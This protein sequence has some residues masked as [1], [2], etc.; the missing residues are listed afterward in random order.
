MCRTSLVILEQIIPQLHNQGYVLT[1]LTGQ[2]KR[3]KLI[4]LFGT[5]DSEDAKNS[6]RNRT[7]AIEDARGCCGRITNC[8]TFRVNNR[9]LEQGDELKDLSTTTNV[10]EVTTPLRRKNIQSIQ[11]IGADEEYIPK[12]WYYDL[13]LFLNERETKVGRSYDIN[14]ILNENYENKD[15][16]I[17]M[18]TDQESQLSARSVPPPQSD[19]NNCKK[20]E[21]DGVC[22]VLSKISKKLDSSSIKTKPSFSAF[23]EHVA[24]NL[25]AMSSDSAKYCQKIINDAIFFAEFDNLNHTSRIVKDHIHLDRSRSRSQTLSPYYRPHRPPS[26]QTQSPYQ[27]PNEQLYRSPFT[28]IQLYYQSPNE[29]SDKLYCTPSVQ[30]QP[31]YQSPNVQSDKL[32]CTPSTQTQPP[33][34]SP[35]EQSDKLYRTPSTQTQPPYQSPNEQ[36]DRPY[37]TPS[38]QTQPPYQS[39]NEQSD[40]LYRTPS[41]Q[42]QPPYQS[43]NEQSDRP[44]RTPSTQTQPPCQSPNEQ[45]DKL[46]RTPSTQT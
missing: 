31:S 15:Q 11:S 5:L 38:T 42:T 39:P 14:A 10:E 44:Y 24:E 30:T 8:I 4:L 25:R 26:T 17:S 27:S 45:S 13:L 33:Y 21:R 43:P 7:L 9:N 29:Q 41:T 22:E 35:N 28:Q 36:S 1:E 20:K 2:K 12:L 19:S 46:Y 3:D 40:K 23:G 37:R 6:S 16:D 34:Q 18:S 32:Y